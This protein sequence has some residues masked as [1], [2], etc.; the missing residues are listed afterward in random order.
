MWPFYTL[1]QTMDGYPEDLAVSLQS[2]CMPFRR[3]ELTR[4]PFNDQAERILARIGL[5]MQ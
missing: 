2:L 5:G 1:I 3:A 4:Q